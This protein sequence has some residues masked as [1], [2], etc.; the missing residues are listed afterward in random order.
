MALRTRL[1][2]R[3]Q[4]AITNYTNVTY[5]QHAQ[6]H[7]ALLEVLDETLDKLSAANEELAMAKDRLEDC[8]SQEFNQ[9]DC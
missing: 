5:W 6:L 3:A 2:E 9:E 1:R 7:E 4:E 8:R